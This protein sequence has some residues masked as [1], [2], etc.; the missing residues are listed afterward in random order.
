MK[1]F[2]SKALLQ[3]LG[4]LTV[5]LSVAMA[6]QAQQAIT[7]EESIELARVHNVALRQARYNS[8]KSDIEVR[9][10]KYSYLPSISANAD[11]SRSN[12]LFFD[13]V[14]GEVKRGTT[15][16][17]QPYLVGEVVLFDGFTKLHEL[18][19]AKQQAAASTYAVQQAEIDLETNITAYYLQALVDRE[20]IRIAEGRIT[21][22]EGQLEKIE[23]LERAGVR[24]LD[25][26]YQ[27]K[28]QLATEK[29][30]LITHQNN[31]RRDKLQLVQEMNVE[32]NPE[33]TLQV[34]ETPMALSMALPTEEEVLQR[35][36]GY[37]PQVKASAA[38]LAAAK[39]NLKIARSN[40]SPT[41]ALQGVYSSN[42]SSNFYAD[43][44]NGNFETMKYTD[45][46]DLNRRKFVSLSLIIPVFNGLSRH[47]D[48]QTARL[49]LRNAEL[50]Y[51]ASQNQLRQTVQQAYQDV[52]AAREKYTTVT[53]NL[54]YTQRAFESAR[55]RYEL[56]NIDF[57]SYM[58]SLNNMNKSQ[59]EL[60]QSQ[61]EFYFRMRILEL[62]M[63]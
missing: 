30:N 50:D 55:R 57:F 21:L 53:A 34:P 11:V 59:A 7:L 16:T 1:K 19:Q 47:F 28:A 43:P 60:L 41:L 25:E 49:D 33:Y 38:S 45:Q 63:G 31:Y 26:V 6:T 13:N 20:N 15:S 36:L 18:K 52:L 14:A 12:G 17:S 58:E 46:L 4:G 42:Y 27:I 48:S 62:Y 8:T 24:A 5:C 61:C 35:S 56:G 32:G 22:L 10:S 51:A 9:R 39:S 44:E 54:E 40:F 23:K 29:L 2:T 3:K 37:S